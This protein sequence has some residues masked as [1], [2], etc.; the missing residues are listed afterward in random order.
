MK[1]LKKINL[2]PVTFIALV[3]VQAYGHHQSKK[4]SQEVLHF[5]QKKKWT[6]NSCCL[7]SGNLVKVKLKGRIISSRKPG[8]LPY[9]VMILSKYKA[10]M[11]VG[12]QGSV[13]SHG[14]LGWHGLRTPWP[15]CRRMETGEE[16][17]QRAKVG[18]KCGPG[19][20]KANKFLAAR[21]TLLRRALY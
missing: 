18:G 5:I 12:S 3:V 14:Y 4:K 2:N 15:H 9:D 6:G 1:Y 13:I 19:R 10:S 7:C 8:M 21:Q 17:A 11:W 20:S 16:K